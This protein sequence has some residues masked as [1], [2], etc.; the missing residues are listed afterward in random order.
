[1]SEL[2]AKIVVNKNQK[3]N[4]FKKLKAH[5]QPLTNCAFNKGGDMYVSGQQ[6]HHGE[7]R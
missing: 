5:L 6:V 7:L 3:F 2:Q 1:M 4:I